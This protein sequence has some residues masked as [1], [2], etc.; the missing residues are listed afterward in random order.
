M[1]QFLQVCC[2]G[3]CTG[4]SFIDSTPIPVC[5]NKRIRRNKVFKG[6]ALIGKSTMG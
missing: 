6:Y 2:L 4:I 5:H 1:M 3:R